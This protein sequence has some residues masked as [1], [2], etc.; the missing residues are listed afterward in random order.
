ML[1][2]P[3]EEEFDSPPIFLKEGHVFRR[4]DRSIGA[5]SWVGS[6]KSFGWHIKEMQVFFLPFVNYKSKQVAGGS[7]RRD[8]TW[9][10]G[11]DGNIEDKPACNVW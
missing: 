2:D 5:D 6:C 11:A 3:L 9:S 10:F 7:W 1:L 4:N 8:I